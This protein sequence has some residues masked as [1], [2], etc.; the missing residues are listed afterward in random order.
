MPTLDQL[1][2]FLAVVDAGSFAAAAR[3]L[4]RAVSVVSYG[5]GNLEAQLGLPLFDRAGTRRPVLTE[6]GRAVLAEARIVAE[7]MDGLRAR[8]RGLLEGYEAEVHLAVDV[9]LPA[10]RL[11]TVLRAFAAAFPTVTLRLHV[12]ALGAVAALVEQARAAIGI[13]G[14]QATACDTVERTAAGA[15]AMVPVAAPDHPLTAGAPAP[16]AARDHV[17]LVLSDRSSI[18]EGRDYAVVARRTWRLADLG[19]KHALLREGIGWGNM[20][21]PLVEADLAAGRL[22]RLDLPERPGGMYRFYGIWRRDAAPGPA[23]RWLLDQFVAAGAN[24]ADIAGMTD[25]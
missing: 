2:L 19:A 16:G 23:A 18:T 5:I 24:D 22:V 3:R 14:P 7:G 13:S 8:V 10:P 15:L 20:P 17:Q 11:A 6:A 4:N 25:L 9:M 12:E 21:L 1:R